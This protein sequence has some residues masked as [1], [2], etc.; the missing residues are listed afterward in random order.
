MNKKIQDT[1]EWMLVIIISLP[2]FIF[3]FILIG[4][5]YLIDFIE[6]RIKQ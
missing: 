2:L 6:E 5:I 1:L 3:I 4:M